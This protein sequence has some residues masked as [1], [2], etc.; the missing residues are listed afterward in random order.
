MWYKTNLRT[1]SEDMQACT[2]TVNIS[3]L[4]TKYNTYGIDWLSF[5]KFGLKKNI[6]SSFL[7][8]HEELSEDV[9]YIIANTNENVLRN[10]VILHTLLNTD[11][12]S[13]LSFKVPVFAVS[14][15]IYNKYRHTPMNQEEKCVQIIKQL[16]PVSSIFVSKGREKFI[17]ETEF[18]KIILKKVLQETISDLYWIPN[19]QRNALRNY[20][21][22]ININYEWTVW[23]N[24]TYNDSL[25]N[26]NISADFVKNTKQLINLKNEWYLEGYKVKY[27]GS[28]VLS[29]LNTWKKVLGKYIII[30]HN[31]LKHNI[32]Y[33]MQ[34]QNVIE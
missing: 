29:D 17:V 8:C 30:I 4:Q 33:H 25:N 5:F 11:L 12:Y 26:L 2:K 13:T 6:N 27:S 16:I 23:S 1:V 32:Y 28:E 31:P 15:S 22:D 9:A 20:I 14:T 3:T 24:S 10:Y 18:L 7:L 21:N 34:T 19:E